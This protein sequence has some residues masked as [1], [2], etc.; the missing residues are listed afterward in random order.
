[1]VLIRE[2]KSAIGFLNEESLHQ[3][4]VKSFCSEIPH[5]NPFAKR[6]VRLCIFFLLIK[7][8]T[9]WSSRRGA[10]VNESD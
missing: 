7:D 1:M 9:L 10:V 8:V 3:N 2:Y 5:L 6:K 4:M